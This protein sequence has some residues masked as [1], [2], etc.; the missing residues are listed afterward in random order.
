[1]ALAKYEGAS[2]GSPSIFASPDNS[3]AW[4]EATSKP[5][6]AG[7]PGYVA[8]VDFDLLCRLSESEL[9]LFLNG[10]QSA[11]WG[12]GGFAVWNIAE[13]IDEELYENISPVVADY[14]TVRK[15]VVNLLPYRFKKEDDKK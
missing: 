10:P 4:L 2:I 14:D 9:A 15:T 7:A 3:G 12:E 11:S 5:V 8:N 1:M 13:H 6:V